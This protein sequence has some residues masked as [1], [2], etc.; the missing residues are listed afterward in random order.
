M[1]R[2]AG[3]RDVRDWRHTRRGD[4]YVTVITDLT[5]VGAGTGPAGLPTHHPGW[6]VTEPV[7]VRAVML[8]AELLA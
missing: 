8:W 7:C 1:P 2:I 4:M 5:A 3:G 6:M